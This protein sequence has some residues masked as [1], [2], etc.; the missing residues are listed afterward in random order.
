MEAA[1][2]MSACLA[3]AEALEADAMFRVNASIVRMQHAL[4][5]GDSH[6]ADRE[7]K[8]VEERRLQ[9]SYHIA[10]HSHLLYQVCA[11]TAMEDLT[12]L[13]QTLME[14]VP[15]AEKYE[16]WR[17]VEQYGKAEYQRIRGD[18]ASS[19]SLL[20]SALE[21]LH[22]GDSAVWPQLAAAQVRTLASAGQLERAIA[23]GHRYAA[24]ARAA[25]MGKTAES[26]IVLALEIAR[27]KH[28][29]TP[30]GLAVDA[31]IEDAHKSGTTG[32]PL[33]LAY[34]ARAYVALYQADRARYEQ[35]SALAEAEFTRHKNPALSARLQRLKREA[36]TNQLGPMQQV[37]QRAGGGNVGLTIL[38]SRLNKCSHA[39]ERAKAM[40][41]TLAQRAGAMRGFLF[42]TT[43][44]GPSLSASLA[45]EVPDPLLC[46]MVQDYLYAETQG[47][48]LNTGDTNDGDRSILEPQWTAFG[49]AQYRHVLLS[50]YSDSG[51]CVTGVAV[52]VVMAG[53]PFNY[54]GETASQ[55]SQ[56]SLDLGDA[57]AILVGEEGGDDTGDSTPADDA[58]DE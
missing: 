36:Q 48:E 44:L 3:S 10:D 4:W 12:R 16:G 41:L 40:L 57:T 42:H 49:E 32:L 58:A 53:Q 35:Y 7:R 2:G 47:R 39:E 23:L 26:H 55:V 43:S 18:A 52:F 33:G 56:L 34:E 29:D 19:L 6:S 21:T 9:S 1:L 31:V 30:A 54:P 20:G 51:Y 5:Q 8:R 50:H 24:E 28:G 45:D 11:Y 37:L 25:S 13:K 46:A 27:A 17:W 22:A 15:L 38:K 14:V